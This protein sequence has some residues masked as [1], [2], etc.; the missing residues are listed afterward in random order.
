VLFFPP[1]CKSQK[2]PQD[3][4]IIA[5]LKKRYKYLYLKEVLNLADMNEDE[6]R[7]L[8][9]SGRRLQRGAAGV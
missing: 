3:Q 4:G 8:C 6:E 2:Q 7:Q 9:K 1:N 5:A